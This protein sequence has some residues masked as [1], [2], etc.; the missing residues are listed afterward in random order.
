MPDSSIART[1]T[2]AI[3]ETTLCR[4]HETSAQ[5]A[6]P[7]SSS[8]CLAIHG[9]DVAPVLSA[10]SQTPK[11]AAVPKVNAG[12]SIK[13]PGAPTYARQRN[14]MIKTAIP[15]MTE[16]EMIF[17][18][19]AMKCVLLNFLTLADSLVRRVS[20]R[21][22]SCETRLLGGVSVVA[23]MSPEY[24]DRN[25]LSVCFPLSCLHCRHMTWRL[26]E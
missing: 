8:L 16:P 24:R 18:R 17:L 4:M 6:S 9:P 1:T 3:G 11:P 10:L 25:S 2:S 12:G 23:G 15:K 20:S 19:A 14:T 22:S 21:N 26:L 7:V 5:S 13:T